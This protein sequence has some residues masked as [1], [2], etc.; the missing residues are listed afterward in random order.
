MINTSAIRDALD[1]I[2]HTVTVTPATGGAA[3]SVKAAPR[4]PADGTA[5]Y[6]ELGRGLPV[7]ARYRVS[8]VR[9]NVGD[10]ITYN[11][12]T[13]TAWLVEDAPMSTHQ[14]LVCVAPAQQI[15][16]QVA[17]RA[18]DSHGGYTKTMSDAATFSGVITNEVVVVSNAEA[19]SRVQR[20]VLLYPRTVVTLSLS[21]RVRAADG[22]EFNIT[23]IHTRQEAPGWG[24]ATLEAV[25]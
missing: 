8:G 13:S 25:S 12:Q 14:M 19:F 21:E 7:V 5:R 4:R 15:T 10:Q 1:L 24:S 23:E 3:F 16:K 2:S 17:V 9:V 22:S 6:T 20:R 11:G 18:P